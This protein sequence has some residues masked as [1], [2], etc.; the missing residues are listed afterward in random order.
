MLPLFQHDRMLRDL[1]SRDWS[2]FISDCRQAEFIPVSNSGIVPDLQL[3][4]RFEATPN[5]NSHPY[6]WP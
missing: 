6:V 4:F 3:V 2:I 5:K 1:I